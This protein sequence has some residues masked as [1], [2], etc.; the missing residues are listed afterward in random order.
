MYVIAP[1]VG[2]LFTV[3]LLPGSTWYLA[4]V[5]S[6]LNETVRVLVNQTPSSYLYY[7]SDVLRFSECQ[8]VE[9]G[10]QNFDVYQLLV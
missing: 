10:G 7:E 4:Q 6:T 8:L 5:L 1:R 3:L 9:T 2:M